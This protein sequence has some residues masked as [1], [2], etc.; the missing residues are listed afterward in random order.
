M[1]K[2]QVAA[3]L[4]IMSKDET[5][6]ILNCG[7]VDVLN[8]QVVLVATDGYKMTAVYVDDDALDLVGTKIRRSAFERW[9]KLADGKSRLTGEE[10][11]QLASEDYGMNNGYMDGDY[12]NWK[13]LIPEGVT[14]SIPEVKFNAEFFKIIQDLNSDTNV[15]V[16]FHGPLSPMV[17]DHE[18]SYSLVTPMKL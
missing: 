7:Y 4:K 1:D 13:G 9:Y 16:E 11:V 18:K 12:P 10:L 3:F 8:D 6:P 2:K 14:T 15:V 5:R 17:I